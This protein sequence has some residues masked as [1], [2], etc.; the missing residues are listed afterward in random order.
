MKKMMIL[1]AIMG[2]MAACSTT[3][4]LEKSDESKHSNAKQVM[5]HIHSFYVSRIGL[6]DGYEVIFHVMPAPEGEGFSRENYHLMVSIKKDGK[7][8]KDLKVYSEIYHADGTS[9]PKVLMMVMNE[10]YMTPYHLERDSGKHEMI[11]SFE[12]DGKMYSSGIEY[13]E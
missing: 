4:K 13:P 7:I 11:V 2:L 10:W 8:M 3:A 5:D 12:H 1:V 6:D 9:E